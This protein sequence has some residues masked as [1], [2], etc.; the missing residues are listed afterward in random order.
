MH[1]LL[2]A[3][4]HAFGFDL[5]SLR[6]IHACLNNRIQVTKVGSFYSEILQIICGVPQGSILGPLLFNVNL[7]DLFLAEYYIFDFSDYADDTTPYNCSSTFSET[8][9]DLEITLDN[10]FNWFCYN[11]FKAKMSKILILKI[12]KIFDFKNVIYSYRLLMKNPLILK[13]L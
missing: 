7:I 5:K 4:L 10:L 3:K 11:N 12:L 13:V 1:D 9:S 8:I 6:V 2:I